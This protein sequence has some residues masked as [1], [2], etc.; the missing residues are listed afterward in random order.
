MADETR[1]ALA[2]LL[3]KT[4]AVPG[5][6]GRAAGDPTIARGTQRE[7]RSGYCPGRR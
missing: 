5:W 4:E 1:M 7:P 2:E 3:R 6:T